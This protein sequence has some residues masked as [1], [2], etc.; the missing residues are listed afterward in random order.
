ALLFPPTATFFTFLGDPVNEAITGTVAGPGSIKVAEVSLLSPAQ[1]FALQP[2]S[3]P[4]FDCN[5]SHYLPST[6]SR[7]VPADFS[8]S[9]AAECLMARTSGIGYSPV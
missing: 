5:G 9:L 7:Y 1:L 2:A 3:F 6:F 4:L 8:Y